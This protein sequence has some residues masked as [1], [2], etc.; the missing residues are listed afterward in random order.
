MGDREEKFLT[1][2]KRDLYRGKFIDRRFLVREKLFLNSIIIDIMRIQKTGQ[3]TP[4]ELD[5]Y[6]SM[7]DEY[8]RMSATVDVMLNEEGSKE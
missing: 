7:F 4:V 2:L 3:P 5:R 8:V 1:D 6:Q